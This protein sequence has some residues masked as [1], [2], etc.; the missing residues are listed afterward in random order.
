MAS[1]ASPQA[2][3][4]NARK[5]LTD[6]KGLIEGLRHTQLDAVGVQLHPTQPQVVRYKF[7]NPLDD[8]GAEIGT[9]AVNLR[10]VP[11]QIVYALYELRNGK[12]SE[13][14]S[15]FPICKTP[16][17][18]KGRIKPDLKG[19]SI[20]DVAMIEQLQ[21]Y[22]GAHWLQ[23]IKELADEHK[24]RQQIPIQSKMVIQPISQ[25]WSFE[26]VKTNPATFRALTGLPVPIPKTMH[27]NAGLTDVIKFRDGTPV[28]DTLEICQAQIASVVDLFNPLFE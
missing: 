22:N 14:R 10:A 26:E 4:K 12:V 24:H 2:T 28:V 3:L 1:L 19:L 23:R 5:H 9:I 13:H 20:E 17:D 8:I 25:S 18:F 15:Q 11:D 27:V 16:N 6:L 21:P 7:T